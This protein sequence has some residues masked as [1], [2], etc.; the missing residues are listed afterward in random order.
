MAKRRG[1]DAAQPNDTLTTFACPN[2]D[3]ANFNR[4]A[5]GNLSVCERM[6]K[7]QHIRRLYCRTCGHRFSERQGTLLQYTKLPE[8]TV[9]QIVKCLVHGCSIEATADICEVT[10]RTV[11]WSPSWRK[12]AAVP[13]TSIA[14]NWRS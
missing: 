4:F 3:C 10:P 6:G 8:K 12:R 2:E 5:A 7:D 11:R 9:V 14:C 13:K 1:T